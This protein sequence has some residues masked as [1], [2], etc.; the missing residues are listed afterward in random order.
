M[1]AESWWQSERPDRA[2]VD[3]LETLLDSPGAVYTSDGRTCFVRIPPASQGTDGRW[4][5]VQEHLDR[6]YS[7]I[8]TDRRLDLEE[9]RKSVV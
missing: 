8:A 7:R 6:E 4:D 2:P 5:F 9:D 3:R 1:T